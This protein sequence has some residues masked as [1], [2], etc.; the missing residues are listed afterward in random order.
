MNESF[1]S[2]LVKNEACEM[3]SVCWEIVI[4]DLHEACDYVGH[5]VKLNRRKEERKDPK[6][7]IQRS[8]KVSLMLTGST[9]SRINRESTTSEWTLT[10]LP[11]RPTEWDKTRFTNL[12]LFLCLISPN[13]PFA[14]K[15]T[16]YQLYFRIVKNACNSWNVIS[17]WA[18]AWGKISMV[19]EH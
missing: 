16:F 12:D 8:N 11:G 2:N 15:F 19:N 10:Q 13:K 6:E 9:V 1:F 14:R 4:I 7:L 3:L 17:W 5:F 18:F